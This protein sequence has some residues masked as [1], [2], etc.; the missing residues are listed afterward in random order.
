MLI[1]GGTCSTAGALK[2]HRIYLLFRLVLHELRR[3]FLPRTAVPDQSV[4]TGEERVPVTDGQ[5][6]TM[7]AYVFLY[8]A[9]WLAGAAV[10]AAHGYGLEESLFEFASALGTVGLSVGITGPGAPATV[11]WTETVG[12]ILGRLEF[13]VIFTSAARLVRDAW[14]MARREP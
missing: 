8:L 6:R 3:P 2:Q 9:T 7:A 4:W 10:L 14:R 5:V 12:M 1:G 13:F 11:L